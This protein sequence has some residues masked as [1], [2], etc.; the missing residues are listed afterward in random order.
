MPLIL[1]T[2]IKHQN[3]K[4]GDKS[5]LTL[6][7]S[8]FEDV[9][10]YY[11]P[12]ATKEVKEDRIEIQIPGYGPEDVQ[13]TING[14]VVEIKGTLGESSFNRMYDLSHNVDVE[15]LKAKVDRGILTVSL[16]K[17]EGLRPRKILVE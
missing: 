6:W 15:A 1:N 13:V 9:L 10:G 4:Q 17:K 11:T 5:M 12:K 2:P 3:D 8:S 7:R 16:P 14:R